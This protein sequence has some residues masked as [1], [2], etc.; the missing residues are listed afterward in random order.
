MTYVWTREEIAIIGKNP[1]VASISEKGGMRLDKEFMDRLYEV[2]SVHK[3]PQT[4]QSF[5]KTWGFPC[6][7][8]SQE[9]FCSISARLRKIDAKKARQGLSPNT[10]SGRSDDIRSSSLSQYADHPLVVKVH[11]M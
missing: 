11:L 8:M 3:T 6:E 1:H 10:S 7:I 2:W 9:F 5:F 4:I